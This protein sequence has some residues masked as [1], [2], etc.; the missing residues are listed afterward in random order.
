MITYGPEFLK[1]FKF[2]K[3]G[4]CLIYLGEH[5]VWHIVSTQ[6]KF[7][8]LVRRV[9]MQQQSKKVPLIKEKGN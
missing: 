7:V 3:A 5:G 2:F 9:R 1:D 6:Y 8:E 4:P